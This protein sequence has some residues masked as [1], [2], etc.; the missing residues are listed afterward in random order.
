MTTTMRTPRHDAADLPGIA[1]AIVVHDAKV[2]MV[3]RR[4]PEGQLVWQFPAG[5]IEAGETTGQA[6]IRETA[7][8]TG[9][10]VAVVRSLGQR[11]HPQ[12]GRHISYIICEAL[13]GAAHVAAPR[14]IADVAWCAHD[15][16]HQ[17]VPDGL[18]EPVL[19][20]LDMALASDHPRGVCAQRGRGLSLNE[21]V[22][23]IGRELGEG[24]LAR[25]F[26]T[27]IAHTP[28]RELPIA[29]AR[30]AMAAEGVKAAVVRAHQLAA[31]EA[32]GE[33]LPPM[34]D[35]TDHVRKVAARI[36]AA[37]KKSAKALSED[38]PSLERGSLSHDKI[39]W[40]NE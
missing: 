14:E 39:R 5:V 19:T 29:L 13:Y 2:L 18:Y 16:F 31:M 12:T 35:R 17:H 38:A 23:H 33:P 22:E 28:A 30:W 9:L 7:E 25:Q 4:V 1:A 10:A 3:R 20:Y 24:P 26:L 27:Q 32:A 11:V 15:Q 36:R 37:D 40:P 21:A 8:E 34:V 6:A